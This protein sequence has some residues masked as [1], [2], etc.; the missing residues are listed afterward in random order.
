MRPHSERPTKLLCSSCKGIK[1]VLDSTRQGVLFDAFRAASPDKDVRDAIER[2][3]SVC[4]DCYRS[5]LRTL[6]NPQLIVS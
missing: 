4:E 2:S 5:V 6:Q 1:P 3:E